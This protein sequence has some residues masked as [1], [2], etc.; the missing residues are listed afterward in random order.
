MSI[1]RGTQ[2]LGPHNAQLLVHTRRTGVASKAGH[3]LVIEVS[4]WTGTLQFDA[5][6]AVTLSADGSSLRVRDGRGGIQALGDDEKASIKQSIDDDVLKRTAITFR[7]RSVE[8]EAP[9]GVHGDLELLGTTRPITFELTV[10]DEGRVTGNATLR[11]SGWG[12]RPFSILF[13]TLKVAD[14]VEVTLDAKLDLRR[15]SRASSP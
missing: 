10:T 5:D 8:G 13:G 1:K 7:S 15:A 14:E 2:T 4:S 11:Q 12:I 6:P 3:D 9:I